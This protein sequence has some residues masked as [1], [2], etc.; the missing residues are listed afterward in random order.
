MKKLKY[1]W[2]RLATLLKGVNNK[3]FIIKFKK[4]LLFYI[5]VLICVKVGK[6][7]ANSEVEAVAGKENKKVKWPR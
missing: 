5:W 2:V 4:L 7:V 1:A 6:D 3:N